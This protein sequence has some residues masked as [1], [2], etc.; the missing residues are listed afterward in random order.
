MTKTN[1]APTPASKPTRASVNASALDQIA[2]LLDGQDLTA[3]KVDVDVLIPMIADLVRATGRRVR[4]AAKCSKWTVVGTTPHG[5]FRDVFLASSAE[6][7]EQV[8]LD[9]HD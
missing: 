5:R 9:V 8:A 3:A 6:E 1:H 4:D 7:A 2:L